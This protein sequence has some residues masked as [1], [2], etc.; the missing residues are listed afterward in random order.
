MNIK[1][2][3]KIS[4]LSALTLLVTG[5]SPSADSSHSFTFDIAN[6]T[7]NHNLS[8]GSGMVVNNGKLMVVGDDSPWL[9]SVNNDFK[10]NKK[11]LIE[12]FP[13]NEQNR[14]NHKIK[15]DFESMTMVNYLNHPYYLVM[16]S[17]SKAVLREQA[18]LMPVNGGENQKLS[19]SNLYAQLHKAANF[20]QQEKINIEGIANTGNEIFIFN[21]GNEGKNAIFTINEKELMDYLEGKTQTL[22]SLK[23]YQVQLP[24][25]NGVQACF[26][27]ADYWKETNSM[28]FTAS[29]EGNNESSIN[30]GAI[31]GSFIGVLPLKALVNKSTINLTTYSQEIKN[32]GKAV[33]TKAESIAIENQTNKQANGYIVSDNDNGTS[34]FFTFTINK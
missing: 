17:G 11:T 18:Y 1:K 2:I 5:C 33:I 6:S 25:I 10:I 20:T 28:V 19:L 4:I 9:F 32:N 13:V 14:I 34:Q 7:I 8:S 29:V 16:G 12:Q 21:R 31:Q 27:G 26:S 22:S 24:K 23:V 15:P 3:A 30:D